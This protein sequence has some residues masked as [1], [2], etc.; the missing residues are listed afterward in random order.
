MLTALLL[1]WLDTHIASELS[2][3]LIV[4]VACVLPFVALIRMIA[5]CLNVGSCS[6]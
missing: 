4:A 3:D 5:G 1:F 6:W 2:C